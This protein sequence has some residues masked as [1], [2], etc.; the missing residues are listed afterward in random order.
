MFVD[1]DNLTFALLSPLTDTSGPGNHFQG[2]PDLYP[3]SFLLGQNI[4]Y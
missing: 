1:V 2:F 3:I 4:F